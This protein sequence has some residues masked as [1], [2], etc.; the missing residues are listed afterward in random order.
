MTLNK[1]QLL[2][3]EGDRKRIRAEECRTVKITDLRRQIQPGDAVVTL[4]DGTEL[5]LLWHEVKGAFAA[6]G[7][8]GTTTTP[9]ALCPSCGHRALVLRLPPGADAW[10]CCRCLSLIYPTQRRPGAPKGYQKPSTHTIATICREQERIAQLL[11]L[12]CW[13]PQELLWDVAHLEPGRRLHPI[14]RDALLARID[15][16]ETLRVI[17]WLRRMWRLGFID[18]PQDLPLHEAAA[19][20]LLDA[21][22]WAMRENWRRRPCT[23]PAPTAKTSGETAS[24][25]GSEVGPTPGTPAPTS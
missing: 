3:A 12:R 14:R 15:A 2:R 1:A 20:R 24:P 10:G 19:R 8:R 23:T 4:A 22:R 6:G 13:P 18:R 11:D 9:K 5:D 21:T 16:L 17:C 25:R 7:K